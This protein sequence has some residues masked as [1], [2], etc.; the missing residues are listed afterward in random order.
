M[1]ALPFPAAERELIGSAGSWRGDISAVGV[2][3]LLVA[4]RRRRQ[5]ARVKLD[6]TYVGFS[7][8]AFARRAR[9]RLIEESNQAA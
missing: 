8:L 4:S 3:R 1:S 5:L 6:L 2:S 9:L 7:A